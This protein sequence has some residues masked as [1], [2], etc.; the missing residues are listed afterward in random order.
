MKMLLTHQRLMSLLTAGAML[1]ATLG[2]VPAATALAAFGTAQGGLPSSIVTPSL[3]I[4][5]VQVS[6]P[7]GGEQRLPLVPIPPMH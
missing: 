5:D 4:R 1:L 2:L 3:L 6:G 7:R